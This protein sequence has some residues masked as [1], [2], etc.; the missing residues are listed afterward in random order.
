MYL[1]KQLHSTRCVAIFDEEMMT[2]SAIDRSND[3]LQ[4]YVVWLIVY[5][6]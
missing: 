5:Y 2:M 1:V 3:V 4:K 6:K